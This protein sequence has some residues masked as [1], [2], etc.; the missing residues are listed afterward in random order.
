[1]EAVVPRLPGGPDVVALQDDDLG[2]GTSERRG[3]RE[4]CGA[5]ADDADHDD[6]PFA[7]RAVSIT[8]T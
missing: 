8:S 6:P 2:P 4:P 7:S 3:A 5:S 1:M